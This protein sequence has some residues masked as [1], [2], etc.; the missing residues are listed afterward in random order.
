MCI[1]FFPFQAG[2]SQSP[3]WV[4]AK[5]GGTK[6][7]DTYLKDIKSTQ[8]SANGYSY[9]TGSFSDTLHALPFIIPSNGNSDM[10]IALYNPNGICQWVK[11]SGGNSVDHAWSISITPSGTNAIVVGGFTDTLVL[12]SDTLVSNGSKDFFIT[13]ID[14]TGNFLWSRNYGGAGWEQA[15]HASA[16]TSNNYIYVAG[17]FS[18]TTIIGSFTLSAYGGFGYDIFIAKFDS[19][20]NV[21]WATSAGGPNADGVFGSTTDMSGNTYIMGHYFDS[22][23]FGSYQVKSNG[24]QDIYTAKCDPNGNFI[25]AK[26][27]GSYG[28]DR[29]RG[30]CYDAIGNVYITGNFIDTAYF[31]LTTLSSNGLADAF[32]AKYDSSGNEKWIIKIGGPSEDM[33]MDLASDRQGD[34]Y[35]CGSYRD[36]IFFN[37]DLPP[38]PAIQYIDVFVAKYDSSG[39]LK[40]WK[41][42]GGPGWED[43]S[44][45]SVDPTKHAHVI[46]VF[47]STCFFDTINLVNYSQ[48]DWFVSKLDNII[49]TNSINEENLSNAFVIFPNPFS[50]QTVLQ[51]DN[52]LK[53]A[54]LTVDNCLGQ[55]VKQIRNI[56]QQTITL[57]RDNLPSGLYFVRLTQDNKVI[58]AGKLVIADK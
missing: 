48:M 51:T 15:E 4:W 2:F 40:W 14:M 6:Y 54:T 41:V 45:I 49:Y 26:S 20:G 56:S 55:T 30:I 24:N 12:G 23:Y 38:V 31:G 47:D 33:G 50:T 35:V 22:L 1:L 58:A 11:T 3:D 29:A 19:L 9:V 10:F 7:I 27:F 36:W 53:S 8:N 52:P 5:W 13:E 39:T 17:T 21:I 25:W 57:N 37:S 42:A 44:G 28:Q 46:G 16:D 43:A 18:D 34:V 32:I